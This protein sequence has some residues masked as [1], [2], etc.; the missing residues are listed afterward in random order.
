LL[1]NIQSGKINRLRS[2]ANKQSVGESFIPL[3]LAGSENRHITWLNRISAAG[4]EKDCLPIAAVF[5]YLKTHTPLTWIFNRQKKSFEVPHF[6]YLSKELSRI[7]KRVREPDVLCKK[8]ENL[9]LSGSAPEYDWFGFC[10]Q[11][12]HNEGE[13][14]KKGSYFTPFEAAYEAIVESN[15]EMKG[16]WLDPCCG[17]GAFLS[18][19]AAYRGS[20]EQIRGFDIDPLAVSF[21]R[22]Q[23]QCDFCDKDYLP[24]IHVADF[25]TS[26]KKYYQFIATNPPWGVKYSKEEKST[27]GNLFKDTAGFESFALIFMK[28]DEL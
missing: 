7:G 4:I 13:K 2:R 19:M 15:P 3:E 16:V 18:A 21:A 8:L 22:I 17:A 28:S 25:L 10:Y 26:R 9:D 20:P 12:L 5:L 27:L 6:F 23:L 24:D 14:N 1:R 11:V